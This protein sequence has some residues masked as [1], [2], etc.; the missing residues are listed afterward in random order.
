MTMTH[1][2]RRRDAAR[3]SEIPAWALPCDTLQ[4]HLDH[5]AGAASDL[6]NAYAHSRAEFDNGMAAVRALVAQ[7]LHVVVVTGPAYCR[8]TDALIGERH[9]V[10]SAHLSRRVAERLAFATP[11]D[12][13]ERCDSE[14]SWAVYPLPPAPPSPAFKPGPLVLDG[15]DIPF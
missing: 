7:G 4:E 13:D 8:S 1:T 6:Q 2:Q 11:S 12:E 10:V 14:M 3:A 5:E 15:D 9:H